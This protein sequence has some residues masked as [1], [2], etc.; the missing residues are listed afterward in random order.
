MY[1][2]IQ[3]YASLEFITKYENALTEARLRSSKQYAWCPCGAVYEVSLG[4]YYESAWT[5]KN[6]THCV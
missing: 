3:Q 6:F 4:K 5:Q 2:R 1:T